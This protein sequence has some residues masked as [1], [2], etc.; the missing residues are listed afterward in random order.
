MVATLSSPPTPKLVQEAKRT[1]D[2]G[3]L[4][5]SWALCQV[6]RDDTLLIDPN[7]L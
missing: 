2:R 3:A 5:P 6:I 4:A 7:S 1:T